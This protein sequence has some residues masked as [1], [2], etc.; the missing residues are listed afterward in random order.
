MRLSIILIVGAITLFAAGCGGGS[1]STSGSTTGATTGE[2]GSE[3]NAKGATIANSN[4]ANAKQFT[5]G[6]NEICEQV[7][8][9]YNKLVQKLT[10]GGKKNVSTAELNLEAAVPPIH[11]AVEQMETVTP[12]DGEEQKLEK[13]IAALESAAEGLEDKPSS[14]LAGPKSPFAEFQKMTGK[15]GFQSCAAL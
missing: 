10:N 13:S 11:T 14:P 12:P 8:V 5:A 3:G 4:P 2:T 15:Y 6:M 7:P 1:D 9:D